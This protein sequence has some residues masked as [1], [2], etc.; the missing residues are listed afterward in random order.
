MHLRQQ[1]HG[2]PQQLLLLLLQHA[3]TGRSM[4]GQKDSKKTVVC[5]GEGG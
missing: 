2:L 4:G 5:S 1:P 3:Y